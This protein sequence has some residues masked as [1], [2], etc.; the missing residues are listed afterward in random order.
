MCNNKDKNKDSAE[1]KNGLVKAIILWARK[2]EELKEK[3]INTN[4][5]NIAIEDLEEIL[6]Y[7]KN[8][9]SNPEVDF[10]SN[11]SSKVDRKI[12]EREDKE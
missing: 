11:N 8:E 3:V 9:E 4:I 10:I 12:E 7:F 6:Y 1:M 5:N 2:K